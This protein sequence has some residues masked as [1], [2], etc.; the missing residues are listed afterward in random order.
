MAKPIL[1]EP[2]ESPWLVPFDESFKIKK[3]P[4]KADE[5]PGKALNVEAL[6]TA[7]RAVAKLQEK[8]YAD[9][10]YSVLLVF[11]LAAMLIHD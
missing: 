10:R 5:N 2:V 8:L 9:D 7:V 6:E 4:T 1:F 11:Q 3:A